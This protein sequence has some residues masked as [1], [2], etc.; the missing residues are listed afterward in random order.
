M[1]FALLLLIGIGIGIGCDDGD[2]PPADDLIPWPI[3]KADDHAI[4]PPRPGGLADFG[5]SLTAV[6]RVGDHD[7][8][9]VGA[10]RSRDTRLYLLDAPDDALRLRPVL[11]EAT[12]DV[13]TPGRLGDLDDDG[14][15]DLLVRVDS[16]DGQGAD[17]L[18]FH[19]FLAPFPDEGLT[20]QDAFS[21]FVITSTDDGWE[22]F[23]EG[24]LRPVGDVSGDGL[25]D[26]VQWYED[27]PDLRV[28]FGSD[29]LLEG[30]D[31]EPD[32]TLVCSG[33]NPR[34]PGVLTSWRG[35]A[36]LPGL[37]LWC[38]DADYHREGYLHPVVASGEGVVEDGLH[39]ADVSTS[40][41]QHGVDFDHSG[42][43]DLLV[44]GYCEE[45]NY[46]NEPARVATLLL[47]VPTGNS[48]TIEVAMGDAIFQPGLTYEYED[49]EDLLIYSLGD[50]DHL[51]GRARPLRDLGLDGIEDLAFS[52]SNYYDIYAQTQY[53]Y[54]RGVVLVAGLDGDAH[55]W[56]PNDI[57]AGFF[58]P[59]DS[60][61]EGFGRAL[62]T[63]ADLD[64]DGT[65]ELVVSAYGE[66]FE[67]N[68]YVFDGAWRDLVRRP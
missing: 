27:E 50:G 21:T 25:P 14:S 51:Y 10:R 45:P 26:L 36:E 35:G 23:S 6:G 3:I 9:A 65:A 2:S 32:A 38:E 15:D 1:R 57:L 46:Y 4:S 8:V 58:G 24:E 7:L 12:G 59:D 54:W 30:L 67:G 61:S 40:T 66:D 52:S 13:S 56:L 11:P 18:A 19:L 5:T 16:G 41:V 20:A 64:G 48:R 53:K 39:M 17:Q 33:A 47:D 34:Y 60:Q 22:R 31:G 44:P 62:I 49:Q 55:T 37:S 42:V 28:H 68:V 63:D 29:A 43:A